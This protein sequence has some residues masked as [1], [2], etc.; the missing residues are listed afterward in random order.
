M[1]LA[2]V[3]QQLMFAAQEPV[4]ALIT[5]EEA[6]AVRSSTTSNTAWP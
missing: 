6:V 1:R 3:D 2:N 5:M 4:T